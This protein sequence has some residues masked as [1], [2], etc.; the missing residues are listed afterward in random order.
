MLPAA[1]YK[2]G[3]GGIPLV[4]QRMNKSGTQGSSTPPVQV[5]NWTSDGTNPATIVSH[6]LVVRGSGTGTITAALTGSTGNGSLTI[7][8]RVNGVAVATSPNEI[9][10]GVTATLTSTRSFTDGDVV[11]VWV[12]AQTGNG[13]TITASSYVE[14]VPS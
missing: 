4:R 8:L 12:T 1:R 5:I 10:N 6:S 11:S 3:G 9:S 2:A 14:I 7:E 13:R